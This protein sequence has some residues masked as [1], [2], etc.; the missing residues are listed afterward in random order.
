MFKEIEV[1]KFFLSCV[2]T[3]VVTSTKLTNNFPFN[4]R[5]IFLNVAMFTYSVTSEKILISFSKLIWF[6]NE[7]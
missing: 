2:I 3:E 4:C 5:S 6:G 7:K 1:N